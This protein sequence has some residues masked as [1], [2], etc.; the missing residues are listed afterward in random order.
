MAIFPDDS[1]TVGTAD[2]DDHG[3]GMRDL[4]LCQSLWDL[5]IFREAC[6]PRPQAALKWNLPGQ[7]ESLLTL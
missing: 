7:H 3:M 6:R 2:Q 5:L 4:K 1:W